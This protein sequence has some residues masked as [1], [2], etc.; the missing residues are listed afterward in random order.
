MSSFSRSFVLF[1]LDKELKTRVSE[2]LPFMLLLLRR[3]FEF[4]ILMYKF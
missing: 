3:R 1:Y 2:L 4:Y